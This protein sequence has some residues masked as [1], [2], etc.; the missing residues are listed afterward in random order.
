MNPSKRPEQID[1]LPYLGKWILLATA[2]AALAGSASAFFLTALD[3]ATETR[4][5]HRW[6]I[7]LLPLAGFWRWLALSEVRSARRSWQQSA[8]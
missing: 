5:A 1:L 6:L 4:N 2:V 8:H 3:W 7:W